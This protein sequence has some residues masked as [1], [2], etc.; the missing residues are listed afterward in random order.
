MIKKIDFLIIGSNGFLGS[1]IT[2]LLKKNHHSFF[3]V[4][5]NKSD[6]NLDLVHYKKL[7]KIFDKIKFN[8]VINCA[9]KVD[10]VFCEKNKMQ[11][12]KINYEIPKFLTKLSNYYDFKLIQIST[13]HV[14]YSKK[15]KY[16]SE[17]SK[18]KSIN[19]YSKTKIDA[20]NEVKSANKYIII[21]T[22][23]TG[24]KDKKNPT[25]VDWV[26]N[27]AKNKKEILLFNNMF[28]STIDI[29]SCAKYIVKLTLANSKGIYNLGAKNQISKKDFA[30]RFMKQLGINLKYKSVKSNIY[31]IK[32]GE[33]LGMNVKKIE[34]KLNVKM[35]SI[36]KVINN[37]KKDFNENNWN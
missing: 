4:A 1:Q 26:F 12:R 30:L 22:N 27:A 6:F 21:R 17:K 33:Y 23:F 3:T 20:E 28:T 25:F 8:Y 15:K 29:G 34:N 9:A 24:K 13:D 18:I 35:P 5:R 16:N 36:N 2:K 11:A 31:N 32:R 10:L 37:L 7:K 14:Y 19:Y